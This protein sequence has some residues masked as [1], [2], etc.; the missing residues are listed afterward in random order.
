MESATVRIVLAE[1]KRA[2]LSFEEAWYRALRQLVPP[3]GCPPDRRAAH[4]ADKPLWRE[5]KE[6]WRAIYE[7]RPLDDAGLAEGLADA[8]RRLRDVFNADA[9]RADEQASEA[10]Q[11]EHLRREA[12]ARGL[13]EDGTVAE[14]KRRVID[15]ELERERDAEPT[16]P[17]AA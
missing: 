16:E 11:L 5:V 13:A 7:G 14:L 9:R 3:P 1:S 15:W 12:R 4:D 17:L 6:H 2:G 10:R 8:R